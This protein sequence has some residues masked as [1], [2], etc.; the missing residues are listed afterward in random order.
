MSTQPKIVK[1][2]QDAAVCSLP[3]SPCSLLPCICGEEAELDW[4]GCTDWD[5]R[6]WQRVDAGCKE[7][8]RSVSIEIDSDRDEERESAHRLAGGMWNEF[9]KANTQSPPTR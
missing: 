4:G 6:A 3:A 1:S 8:F 7:C 2:T 9:I 5:G